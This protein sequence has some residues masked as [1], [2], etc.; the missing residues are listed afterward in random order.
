MNDSMIGKYLRKCFLNVI[1]WRF[2][3]FASFFPYQRNRAEYNNVDKS[4]PSKVEMRFL[5]DQFRWKIAI[6]DCPGL[7]SETNDFNLMRVSTWTRILSLSLSLF[8][9]LKYRIPLNFR[10][11]PIPN[12]LLLLH[13][14]KISIF[15]DISMNEI[16]MKWSM[17]IT[18]RGN[19]QETGYL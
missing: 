11:R 1:Y 5:E 13:S 19:P 7:T 6:S 2:F 8:L 18:S 9:F 3:F 17:T 12:S 10:C 4:S 15:I 14:R 16:E